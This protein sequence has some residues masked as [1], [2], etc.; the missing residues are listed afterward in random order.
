MPLLLLN[1]T[2]PEV[3]VEPF[4][5]SAP[6]LP[7]AVAPAAT[8]AL[9]LE[10]ASRPN[11]TPE[12]LTSSK[13]VRLLEAVPAE[14][15][16]ALNSP[17]VLG[18]VYDAVTVEPLTPKL[19]PL[20]L[21]SDRP[22]PSACVVPADTERKPSCEPVICELPD[23]PNDRPLLALKTTVPL[24]AVCVLAPMPPMPA[25]GPAATLAVTVEPLIPNDTPLL[26]ENTTVPLEILLPLALI[27]APPPPAPYCTQVE[28][29]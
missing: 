19:R 13:A 18:T 21:A 25:D 15:L 7:V 22:G 23:R 12:P 24:V 4:A 6:R 9:T 5:A 11:D 8:D 27:A 3:A 1:D 26:L 28:P 10:P 29:L 2:V 17:A 16:T 14:R 20:L